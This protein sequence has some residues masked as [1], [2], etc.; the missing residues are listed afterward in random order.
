[1]P[2]FTAALSDLNRFITYL[3]PYVRHYP[4]RTFLILGGA[5][6]AFGWLI[7]RSKRM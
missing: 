2:D 3:E 1:M 5:L 4:E 6:M 7:I